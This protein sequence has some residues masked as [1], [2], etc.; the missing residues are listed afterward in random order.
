MGE[1]GFFDAGENFFEI[2]VGIG[3]F[4]DG[5]FSSVEEDVVLVEFFVDHCL[6]ERAG[7]GLSSETTTGSVVDGETAFFS[8]G[9]SGHDDGAIARVSGQ[10]DGV[11][12]IVEWGFFEGVVTGREGAGCSFSVNPLRDV[13]DDFLAGDVVA[14]EVDELA[15][16]SG[17]D[18]LEGFEDE[19]VDEEMVHGGEV[20]AEGHV[21]EVGVSF[22]RSKGSVD[23]FLVTGRVGDAP[24]FKVCFE[25][26][27]LVF[28]EVMTEAARS[29]VGEEGD[30]AFLEAEDIGSTLGGGV[31]FDGDFFSLAEVVSA[32][33]GAELLGLAGEAVMVTVVEHFCETFFERGNGAIVGKVSRVFATVRP[34]SG[35]AERFADFFGRPLGHDFLAEFSVN[36]AAVLDGTGSFAS[37]GGGAVADGFDEFASDAWI[38]DLVV[39]DVELEERHG[40]LDIDSDRAWVDVGG[41]SHHA[42]DGCAVAEVGIGIED[43]LGDA[44]GGFAVLDLLDGGV[45]E[46]LADR[47]IS[48]HSDGLALGIVGWDE[49]GGGTGEVDFWVH[50]MESLKLKV[51]SLKW[52][53]L[54]DATVLVAIIRHGFDYF[55]EYSGGFAR[56]L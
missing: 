56:A 42:T 32:A 26:F 34:V 52:E 43:H 13:I 20:C 44:G 48:N 25:G 24:L 36:F 35:D 28:S 37:S 7:S 29:A 14:D 16:A 9:E 15:L 27:E 47:F 49:G 33:V 22:G 21:I 31:L 41:R 54:F 53:N 12:G 38:G 17:K 5:I 18:F 23:E 50:G 1:F 10:E 2:L 3:G 30:L 8:S 39:I 46:G 4:V 6:V 55:E 51:F 19:L 45:A 40:T 11:S